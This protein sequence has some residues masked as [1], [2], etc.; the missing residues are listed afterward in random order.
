[1]NKTDTNTL[2]PPAP[3]TPETP[4]EH[5]AALDDLAKEIAGVEAA[6]EQLDTAT[7]AYFKAKSESWAFLPEMFGKIMAVALPELKDVYTEEA[8]LA[9]GEA[10]VPV[11]DKYGWGDPAVSVELA[12]IIATVPL[13]LPTFQAATKY[14]HERKA[15]QGQG[16]PAQ[17][18]QA[19][20]AN[21]ASSAAA[22]N[23]VP[24]A[25]S[26]ILPAGLFAGDIVRPPAP[27]QP[28]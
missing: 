11:A 3:K 12:L 1:M 28:A 2:T 10:M 18:T 5:A 7:A 17:L 20:P 15:A 27:R 25:A 23:A 4:P 26:H 6:A 22:N 24:S 13:A 8:C 14:L 9:W 21:N 16:R 19:P